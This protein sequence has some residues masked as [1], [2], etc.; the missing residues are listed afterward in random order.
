MFEKVRHHPTDKRLYSHGYGLPS[1]H[2]QLWDLDRKEDKSAKKLMPMNCSAGEDSW[3]SLGLQGDQTIN[4]KGN[5]F[6]ILIERTDSEAEA[7]V[8][9]SPD[10]NS[11]FIGW[12]PWCWERLRSGEEAVREWDGWMASPMK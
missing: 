3:E 2:V 4:L 12:I 5:Q 11:Q 10:M 1:G 7:P 6:W 8:F 9:W